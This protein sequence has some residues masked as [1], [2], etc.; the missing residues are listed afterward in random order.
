MAAF[1]APLARRLLAVAG[2]L[3]A[4]YVL[5]RVFADAEVYSLIVPY[6]SYLP[7]ERAASFLFRMNNERALIAHAWDSP[8]V[9]WVAEGF[10]M[11]GETDEEWGV[12]SDSVITDSYWVIV[13]GTSGLLGLG[14]CYGTLI[15]SCLR[16][17]RAAAAGLGHLGVGIGLITA[18]QILDTISNAF[19]SPVAIA[20]FGVAAGLP[21]LAAATATEETAPVEE[22]AAVDADPVLLQPRRRRVIDA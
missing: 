19:V 21:D 17:W 16:A 11:V 7:E 2:A 1:H 8:I 10:R 12:T 5:G 14:L 6:L 15:G 3:G 20:L 22:G 9:G 18:V 13:F 4:A